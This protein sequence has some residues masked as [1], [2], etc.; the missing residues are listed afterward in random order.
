MLLLLF[1]VCGGGGGII[2]QVRSNQSSTQ[3][4]QVHDSSVEV[5]R[6]TLQMNVV[7]RERERER[8]RELKG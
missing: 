7:D 8:E 6:N 1:V 4:A 3:K 2:S 5:E